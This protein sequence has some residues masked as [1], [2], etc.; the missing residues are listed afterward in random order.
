GRSTSTTTARCIAISLTST[1]SFAGFACWSTPCPSGPAAARRSSRATASRRWRRQP[2]AGGSSGRK[3]VRRFFRSPLLRNILAV[4]SG[5]A[6]GQIV[7]FA[8]APLI[9]RIYSPETFGLQGVFLSLVSILSPVVALRYPMA[10]VVADDD[11]G[12][13]RLA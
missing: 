1:I 10:I 2:P 6:A 8:F 7:T 12:A 4:G 11:A 9:T 13:Q 3:P 5:T